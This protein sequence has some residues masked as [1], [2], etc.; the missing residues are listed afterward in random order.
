MSRT[1]TTLTGAA[2]VALLTFGS[3]VMPSYGKGGGLR[4]GCRAK[5]PD[6]T[7]LHATFEDR[8]GGARQKFSAEFEALPS[9]GFRAG[10][11][12]AIVVDT[13]LVGRL[14][15]TA[16]VSGELSG[17][18]EFDSKPEAGHTP[19]PPNFPDVTVGSTVEAQVRNNTVLGCELH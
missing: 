14:T 12:I 19:F 11:R 7:L 13:V 10:Q 5:G 4:I 1:L 3:A 17:Q 2:A 15:L 16:G 8:N 6:Q 18:L 9:G